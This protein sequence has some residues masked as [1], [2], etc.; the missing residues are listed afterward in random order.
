[1]QYSCKVGWNISYVVVWLLLAYIGH[2]GLREGDVG[3]D[4]EQVG[5]ME[6]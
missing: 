2:A 3:Y 1:M 4:I 5:G 6:V